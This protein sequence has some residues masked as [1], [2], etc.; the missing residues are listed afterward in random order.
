LLVGDEMNNVF[1]CF[2]VVKIISEKIAAGRM[3]D[4]GRDDRR[5]LVMDSGDRYAARL[6]MCALISDSSHPTRPGPSLRRL[7]K[8]PARSSR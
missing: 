2:I 6:E 7:G 8:S 5:Q 1:D 4:L 3:P